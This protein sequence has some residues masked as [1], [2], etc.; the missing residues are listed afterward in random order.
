MDDDA[1][2]PNIA[3]LSQ[4]GPPTSPSRFSLSA[5]EVLMKIVRNLTL[6]HTSDG[7]AYAT[8]VMEGRRDTW[9]I[10]GKPF[11]LS[12]IRQYVQEQK[13]SPAQALQEVLQVL[14]AQAFAASERS[15]FYRVA[16][17]G[18]EIYL[19]LA[20]EARRV[21][22]ITSDN[23]RLVQDLSV[24]F[25][26]SG[27]GI[28]LPPPVIG[29]T[30]VP[31]RRVLNLRTEE[32]WQLLV[33]WLLGACC[34]SGPYP[35]L[36]LQ[37]EQGTAKSTV[38]K[39]LKYLIDPSSALIR[40]IPRNEQDLMIAARYEHV[41]AFDNLS[42]MQPWFSDALCRLATGGAFATR[43]LYSNADEI[44]LQAQ[45]PVILNG[46]DDLATRHDL[47]DRAIVLTLSPSPESAR[48]QEQE[49]WKEVTA[50]RPSILGALLSAMQ[51]AMAHR[52][53]VVLPAL[54]RMAD[55]AAWVTA[56]EPGLG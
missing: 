23:W 2:P 24:S 16:S 6:F 38:A 3:A 33:G 41:L 19:D 14:E 18:A 27:K 35:I 32:D 36:I 11:R 5:G 10:F 46:I 51:S 39:I 42:G 4:G 48:R 56:A 53:R 21:A 12:L 52:G 34:P 13:K 30:L 43:E 8:G 29:G 20:D 50:I 47:I 54:P 1:V 28:A 31:L 26:R 44:I 17:S 37:G 7:Q 15:V 45:R 9:P 22:V 55:F 49:I 25:V 40:T